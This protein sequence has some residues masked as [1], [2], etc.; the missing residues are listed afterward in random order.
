MKKIRGFVVQARAKNIELLV[1]PECCITGYMVLRPMSRDEIV[2]LV[3]PVPGGACCKELPAMAVENNMIIGAG[4]V[5]IDECSKLY[6]TY[7]VALSDGTFQK[8]RKLHCFV[9]DHML[10]GSEITVFDTH[11]GRMAILICYDLNL[12]ENTRIAALRGAEIL[13]AP[14]QTGGCMSPTPHCMGLVDREL[15][16]NRKNDPDSIEAEFRSTKGREWLLT[17][18]PSRAHDNGMFLI[19]SNGVGLDGKE[20][21]TGNAMIMDCYGRILNE[22][23]KVEDTMVVAELKSSLRHMATGVRWLKSRRPELYKELSLPT[24]TEEDVHVVRWKGIE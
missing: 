22:T 3:E 21:R 8:H 15:W 16:G 6:N 13:I 20:V 4:L 24:G 17:W 14:H 9:S 18:L 11:L 2:G 1:F 10:S 19:F 7:F 5:E 23:C 12:F